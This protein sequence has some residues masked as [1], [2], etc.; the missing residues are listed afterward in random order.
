MF[1]V[2]RLHQKRWFPDEFAGMVKGRRTVEAEVPAGWT[3]QRPN[4]QRP[5][6]Y[7]NRWKYDQV[8]AEIS[9]NANFREPASDTDTQKVLRVLALTIR[10][11]N[12]YQSAEWP[13]GFK[14]G[15]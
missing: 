3:A 11:M 9:N 15:L 12:D 4:N 5:F 7:L 14:S 6:N 13:P 2:V 10:Q 1:R 8:L